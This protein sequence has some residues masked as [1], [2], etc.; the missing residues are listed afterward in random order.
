MINT[1]KIVGRMA[2]KNITRRKLAKDVH[3]S[4]YSLRKQ[5]KNIVPMKLGTAQ[6]I[7]KSLDISD[8]EFP[9]FFLT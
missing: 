5:I 4:E 2:E 6:I 9:S 8:A 7:Q 3:L 1:S